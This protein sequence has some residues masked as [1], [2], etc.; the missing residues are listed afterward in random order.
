MIFRVEGVMRF[1][2]DS[3]FVS[4]RRGFEQDC[5]Y[6]ERAGSRNRLMVLGLPAILFIT[7]SPPSG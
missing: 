1:I 5:R 3:L 4:L 2:Q 7:N 6:F